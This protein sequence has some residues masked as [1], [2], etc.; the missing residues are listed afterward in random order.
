M[1]AVPHI[2]PPP[3]KK[4]TMSWDSGWGDGYVAG[5]VLGREEP[6]S[7]L[8][9]KGYGS[10]RKRG[11]GVGLVIGAQDRYT[12]PAAS[13]DDLQPRRAN[14]RGLGC[15]APEG[16]SS[17]PT[18]RRGLG[19]VLGRTRAEDRPRGQVQRKHLGRRRR[20]AERRCPGNRTA[21][22]TAS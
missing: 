1:L 6:S 22:R 3:Q 20:T 19:Q 13:L 4:R 2:Y 14:R 12:V 18:T 9:R 16:D 21:L 7:L 15:G 11:R 8:G 5:A 10:G 17:G